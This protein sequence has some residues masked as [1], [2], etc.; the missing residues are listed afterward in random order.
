M[1]ESN[2]GYK[3]KMEIQDVFIK[4]DPPGYVSSQKPGPEMKLSVYGDSI[5]DLNGNLDDLLYGMKDL[6]WHKKSHM[7]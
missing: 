4:G 6:G 3:Y 1:S 7:K 5:E 2:K